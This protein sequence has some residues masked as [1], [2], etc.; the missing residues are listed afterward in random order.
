MLAHVE[1]LLGVNVNRSLYLINC[2]FV[3]VLVFAPE[4]NLCKINTC[5][6]YCHI[7]YTP[8]CWCSPLHPVQ[9]YDPSY[10]L[11][12]CVSTDTS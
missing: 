6:Q 3:V 12:M 4:Y 5:V 1:L 9:W 7:L 11:M 2:V 8:G 10:V